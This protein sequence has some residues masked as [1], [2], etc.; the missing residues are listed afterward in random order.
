MSFVIEYVSG[1]AFIDGVVGNVIDNGYFYCDH[2]SCPFSLK[3]ELKKAG[4]EKVVVGVKSVIFGYHNHE[5]TEK[6]RATVKKEMNLALDVTSLY[7]E[8]PECV[9]FKANCD[10]WLDE[11]LKTSLELRERLIDI[12][13]VK[14]YI[15]T[16]LDKSAKQI[17]EACK[18]SLTVGSIRN[19]KT[20]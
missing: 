3:V 12:E 10:K 6:S 1:R 2:K 7:P 8:K 16:H 18:V 15:L 19:M 13:A 4:D 11:A 20:P 17:K 5:K 14:A 9:D